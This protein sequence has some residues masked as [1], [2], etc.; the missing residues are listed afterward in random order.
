MRAAW[1]GRSHCRHPSPFPL[2]N[3]AKLG[4]KELPTGMGARGGRAEPLKEPWGDREG[5]EEDEAKLPCAPH[6]RVRNSLLPRGAHQV[7]PASSPRAQKHEQLEQREL[8]ALFSAGAAGDGCPHAHLLLLHP[9]RWARGSP[10]TCSHV[11]LFLCSAGWGLQCPP[12]CALS[13]SCTSWANALTALPPS[14]PSRGAMRGSPRRLM[15]S[16]TALRA[17]TH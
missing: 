5:A 16:L 3:F 9:S 6:S 14:P 17:K 1:F 4:V 10:G 11:L 15:P 8:Q 12:G 2:Q 7:D 13:M